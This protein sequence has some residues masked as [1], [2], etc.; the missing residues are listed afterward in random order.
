VLTDLVQRLSEGRHPVEA[1]LR[2]D[3]TPAALKECIDRG[4]VHIRFTQTRGG[5]ELSVPLDRERSDIAAADFAQGTGR[6]RVV[7]ELSLDFEKVRCIADLDLATLA[8]EGYLE[9]LGEV[10]EL[11]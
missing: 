5:T 6:V 3:R 9:R 10:V 2:P 1:T 8:G 7:G 11:V 4:Y